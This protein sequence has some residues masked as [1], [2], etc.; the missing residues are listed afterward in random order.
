[1]NKRRTEGKEVFSIP[2]PPLFCFIMCDPRRNRGSYKGAISLKI[3]Y[4]RNYTSSW[5]FLYSHNSPDAQD[6][7]PISKTLFAEDHTNHP[8]LK[9]VFSPE[10]RGW[11]LNLFLMLPN[12]S[13]L[14]SELKIPMI[15]MNVKQGKMFQNKIRLLRTLWK[16]SL[17]FFQ[18]W[19]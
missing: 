15:F 18:S 17:C 12:F 1:M 9:S 10:F 2:S 4:L 14:T 16:I 5:S 6:A 13:Y 19:Y 8:T 3:Q 7:H 11:F